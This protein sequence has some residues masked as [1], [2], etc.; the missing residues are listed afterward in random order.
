[1]RELG[2]VDVDADTE[3]AVCDTIT[4]YAA[5]CRFRDCDHERSAGCAVLAA[6][7]GGELDPQTL[8]NFQKLQ[9]ERAFQDSKDSDRSNRHHEQNQKRLHQRHEAIRREKLSRRLR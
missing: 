9:R 7:E 1:M 3:R 4:A 5:Q 6:I 2:V 8:V